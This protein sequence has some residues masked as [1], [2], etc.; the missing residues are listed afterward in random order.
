MLS[1]SPGVHSPPLMASICSGVSALGIAGI[2]VSVMVA[3]QK[4][5]GEGGL[6]GPGHGLPVSGHVMGS[7]GGHGFRGDSGG[8]V[9]GIAIPP[10]M[11]G[12]SCLGSCFMAS[13]GM[14]EAAAKR[15]AR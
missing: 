1:H 14:D 9:H 3:P 6:S 12:G 15:G 11:S 10:P 7:I 4:T 2:L 13:P 5:P 8:S